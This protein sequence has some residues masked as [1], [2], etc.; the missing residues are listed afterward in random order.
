[1]LAAE[2]T[3]ALRNRNTPITERVSLAEQVLHEKIDVYLPH[4]KKVLLEW[5][6]DMLSID[7]SSRSC[8]NLWDLL[9]CLWKSTSFDT[10]MFSLRSQ[11]LLDIIIETI[12]NGPVESI[13]NAIE[14]I[15]AT[16]QLWVSSSHQAGKLVLSWLEAGAPKVLD[17]FIETATQDQDRIFNNVEVSAMVLLR[18]E[19]YLVEYLK[20]PNAVL[21]LSGLSQEQAPTVLN[22]VIKADQAIEARFLEL[23]K[24]FPEE[25]DTML[26]ILVSNGCKLSSS[27]L[28]SLLESQ[29]CGWKTRSMILVLDAPLLISMM[30]DV[31][32]WMIIDY[33]EDFFCEFVQQA[34]QLRVM[35]DFILHWM[36][37]EIGDSHVALKAVSNALRSLSETQL[38]SLLNRS[39]TEAGV[40]KLLK[41]LGYE[42]V[43]ESLRQKFGNII[44]STGKFGAKR[45]ILELC[46][47]MEFNP[48]EWVEFDDRFT[49]ME[50][51]ICLLRAR[52]LVSF[53]WKLDVELIQGDTS[54]LLLRFWDV[55]CVTTTTET[56]ATLLSRASSIEN[57]AKNPQVQE[58]PEMSLVVTEC[59]KRNLYHV[60]AQIPW[61]ALSKEHRARAL[62]G[63]WDNADLGSVITLLEHPPHLT[64]MESD[65]S[66][67]VDL[68]RCNKDDPTS[69]ANVA[70]LLCRSETY[71]RQLANRNDLDIVLKAVAT[72][73]IFE[74]ACDFLARNINVQAALTALTVGASSD[75]ISFTKVAPLVQGWSQFP[76][77]FEILCRTAP[78]ELFLQVTA[79][80]V[81]HN[82]DNFASAF[83][84]FAARLDKEPL[85]Y[86]VYEALEEQHFGLLSH[87]VALC[88]EDDQSLLSVA[89]VKVKP[90]NFDPFC[91]WA[92]LLMRDRPN[93][94]SQFGL[95]S[96]LE[97]I[98]ITYGH[99]D[100]R[101]ALM[102]RILYSQRHRCAGRMHLV[103]KAF[104]KVA[105][106][107]HDI[108]QAKQY[109][110]LVE[111][112]CNPRYKGKRGQLSSMVSRAKRQAAKYVGVLLVNLLQNSL[113][114][115][116]T[117]EV[118]T[119]LQPAYYEIL[120]ILVGDD[121]RTTTV[122]MDEAS[123][124]YFRN[125][126]QDYRSTFK[127]TTD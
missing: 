38:A 121:L 17:K 74:E 71:R 30:T 60:V 99:W 80:F 115:R 35:F 73:G 5:A 66:Y 124:A 4:P 52:E 27:T 43:G 126:Y 42:E 2:L 122:F 90:E 85:Y 105:D 44:K 93:L 41:C 76:A 114:G 55:L 57:V 108:Q 107:I 119:A 64:A 70:Q 29:Q 89:A 18:S 31:F 77:I 91:V 28:K 25:L 36:R 33:N 3:R 48:Y 58:T 40:E 34:T 97:L 39:S 50:H 46:P 24:A 118:R 96:L 21:N 47:E 69:V 113:A 84:N 103:M 16:T 19:H 92:N 15:Q 106:E 104:S 81:W 109:V 88:P 62:Q 63:S 86:I 111:N 1:M 10:A 72:G 101:C 94:V 9:S 12:P 8:P 45:I 78:P 82:N 54:P 100:G 14:T 37:C 67:L 79:L 49:P 98:S 56:L 20:A 112:L 120:N 11:K 65:P 61:Q 26:S 125:I 110:L 123:R 116:Y 127:W 95:E 23:L 68:S 117:P 6:L 87:L 102:N 83:K 75:N 13:S 53:S 7:K 59:L 32:D 22:S 51:Q